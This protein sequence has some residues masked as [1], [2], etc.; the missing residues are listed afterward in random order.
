MFQVEQGVLVG[1]AAANELARSPRA[2]DGGLVHLPEFLAG[3][4]WRLPLV[5]QRSHHGRPT[6]W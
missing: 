3:Q 1:D 2:S 6:G 5:D 4:H